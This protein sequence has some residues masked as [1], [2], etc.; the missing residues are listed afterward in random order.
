M[1]PNA[2][3][4]SHQLLK[5]CIQKGDTVVDATAGNGYDTLF[6]TELVGTTG[7]VYAFDIQQEA[8]SQTE[9]RLQENNYSTLV[10]LIQDSHAHLSDYITEP[11]QAAIFN[12]GYLPGSDKSIITKPDSTLHALKSLLPI[13]KLHGRIVIVCYWGHKGGIEELGQ[14]EAFFPTLSQKQWT[15]LRYQF[16]NQQHQPPICFVIERKQ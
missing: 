9:K 7:K 2:Q 11:I 15:V 14:L 3:Q 12:L 10:K 16:M 8:L 13:L 4:F 5:E 6:L 1:L